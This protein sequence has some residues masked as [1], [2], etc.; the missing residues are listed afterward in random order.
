MSVAAVADSERDAFKRA[1]A[2]AAVQLVEQG[3]VV[4]LGTG[5]RR[6]SPSKR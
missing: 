4:G 2:E 3:M 1:A 5:C 6:P